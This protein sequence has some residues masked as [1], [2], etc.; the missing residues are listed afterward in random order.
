[1]VAEILVA[2]DDE[3]FGKSLETFL[4]AMGHSVS[5]L[6]DAQGVLVA[7]E[8]RRYDLLVLDLQM[9]GGGAPAVVRRLSARPPKDRPKILVVSGMPL[10]RQREWIPAEMR[11][12]FLKKP[13]KFPEV[14]ESIEALLSGDR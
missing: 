1:M 4:E 5:C 13:V 7:L 3:T 6:P 2:D 14:K 9:P 8:K 11:A 12:R 10:E